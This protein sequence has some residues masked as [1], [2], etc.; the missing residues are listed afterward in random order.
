MLKG[1]PPYDA[2]VDAEVAKE[3]QRVQDEKRRVKPD[4]GREIDAVRTRVS[5][6]EGGLTRLGETMTAS[7]KRLED[8]MQLILQNQGKKHANIG[9]HITEP[10]SSAIVTAMAAVGSRLASE[11]HVPRDVAEDA[12]TEAATNKEVVHNSGDN[13][14]VSIIEEILHNGGQ[15]STHPSAAEDALV[16]ETL[17]VPLHAVEEINEVPPE[18]EGIAD[19]LEEKANTEQVT[20][21]SW[22]V[23]NSC[24]FSRLGELGCVCVN[25]VLLNVV[26]S[27]AQDVGLNVF[28]D[29]HVDITH[30][31]QNVLTMYEARFVCCGCTWQEDV[32]TTEESPGRPRRVGRSAAKSAMV[33]LSAPKAVGLP[34]PPQLSPKVRVTIFAC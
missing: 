6:L 27:D 5:E 17:D 24:M 33:K 28:A 23:C 3:Y 22:A 25:V 32:H 34:K 15:K 12:A 10:S 7:H 29:I 31:G 30:V 4:H 16:P 8:M 2:E 9:E 13:V 14:I 21:R 26:L 19:V 20:S 1:R 18:V 11:V